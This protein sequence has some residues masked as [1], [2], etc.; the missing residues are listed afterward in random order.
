ME[1]CEQYS[2]DRSETWRRTEHRIRIRVCQGMCA[3]RRAD[4]QA[5]CAGCP[6]ELPVKRKRKGSFHNK[7]IQFS[8]EH[9]TVPNAFNELRKS[10]EEVNN[11][12]NKL[13]EKD[14]KKEKQ[15]K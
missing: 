5:A 2:E 12:L 10:V 7:M 4:S 6:Q 1:A 13:S 9:R 14:K 3:D 8:Y 15:K 11:M